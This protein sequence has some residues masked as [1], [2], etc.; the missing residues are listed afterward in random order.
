MKSWRGSAASSPG[1]ATPSD[2][3]RMARRL[4]ADGGYLILEDILAQL[5][6]DFKA[7]WTGV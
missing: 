5:P 2:H 7:V 6:K 4:K 1:Y 3:T